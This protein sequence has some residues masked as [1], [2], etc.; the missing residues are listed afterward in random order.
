MSIKPIPLC[1]FI[2]NYAN[3]IFSIKT[4]CGIFLYIYIHAITQLIRINTTD[5]RRFYF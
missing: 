4:Y 2:T 1:V 5:Q 3:A